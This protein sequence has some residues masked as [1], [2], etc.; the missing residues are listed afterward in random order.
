MM[1]I[2][3]CINWRINYLSTGEEISEHRMIFFK[4]RHIEKFPFLPE[5]K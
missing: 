3:F 1:K 2:T 4:G 5:L